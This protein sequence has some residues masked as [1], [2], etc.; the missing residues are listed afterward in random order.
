[1]SPQGRT[2]SS[3]AVASVLERSSELTRRSA[4]AHDAGDGRHG[5]PYGYPHSQLSGQP[6]GS[7]APLQAGRDID[8]VAK[9]IR[10]L[11]HDIAEIY[12]DAEVHLALARELIVARAKRGLDLGGAAHGF[13][14]A[15]ELGED[16]VTSG[17]EDA[18]TMQLHQLLKHLLVGAKC[19]QRALF[20]LCHKTA[21]RRDVG[22]EDRR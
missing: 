14:R 4:I 2:R 8:A 15:A 21:V 17:I 9:Q 10:A 7:A 12:V 19:L 11:H 3:L 18:A 22:G 20:V 13:D 1:M 6:P 5:Y 16:S